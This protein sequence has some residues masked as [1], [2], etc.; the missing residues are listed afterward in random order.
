MAKLTEKEALDLLIEMNPLRLGKDANPIVEKKNQFILTGIRK[1]IRGV[2]GVEVFVQPTILT[3]K[4]KK[5]N[6]GLMPGRYIRM[7]KTDM[8]KEIM[9]A[10]DDLRAG[11]K[12]VA[13]NLFEN[14]N[15]LLFSKLIKMLSEKDEKGAYKYFTKMP[16]DAKGN[17]VIILR[18]P[19]PGAFVTL[20]MPAHNRITPNGEI[21]AGA[22]KD[23][24]SGEFGAKQDIVFHDVTIFLL[25]E[26]FDKLQSIA[27]RKFQKE[28]EPM[29]AE[30]IIKITRI[31]NKDIKREVKSNTDTAE[32]LEKAPTTE[33]LKDTKVEYDEMGNPI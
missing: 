5:A 1:T 16:D 20:N 19:V 21:L 27:L 23:L 7:T 3:E 25:P 24:K 12:P 26:E 29:L 18:N 4:A 32:D 10:E 30:E 28:V 33:E 8:V 22:R 15:P 6:P 31:A 9:S 13:D 17:P 11:R 14:Q 2:E